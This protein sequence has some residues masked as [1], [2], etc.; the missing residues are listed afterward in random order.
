MTR[1]RTRRGVPKGDITFRPTDR[2]RAR[3]AKLQQRVD[4][5]TS[6]I[7]RRAW[8]HMLATLERGEPIHVSVPSEQSEPREEAGR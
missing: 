6:D 5:G 1:A 7:I 3:L 2:D 8:I 4:A